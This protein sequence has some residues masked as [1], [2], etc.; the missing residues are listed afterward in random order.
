MKVSRVFKR[1]VGVTVG[2]SV[3]VAMVVTS[4]PFYCM[5]MERGAPLHEFTLVCLCCVSHFC[6]P[7]L[8]LQ[9]QRAARVFLGFRNNFWCRG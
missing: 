7:E 4:L 2:V 5:L 1:F 8:V 9:E 6:R 3:T